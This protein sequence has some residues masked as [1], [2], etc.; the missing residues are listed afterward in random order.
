MRQSRCHGR[1]VLEGFDHGRD[2]TGLNHVG[3]QLT[4]VLMQAGACRSTRCGPRRRSAAAHAR[5]ANRAHLAEERIGA[6][7][8]AH[9]R[10]QFLG[11]LAEVGRRRRHHH[12]PEFPERLV[13]ERFLSSAFQ[14]FNS[15][16]RELKRCC[17]ELQR[18]ALDA[19][20][21]ACLRNGSSWVWK[22]SNR[23][24]RPVQTESE[25]APAE[26]NTHAARPRGESRRIIG[27]SA[28]DRKAGR[29][30]EHQASWLL[31]S[32]GTVKLGQEGAAIGAN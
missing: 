22:R 11:S 12:N 23:S 18:I 26:R 7:A 32:A 10:C 15:R 17:K 6:H 24:R 16:S 9:Q 13:T 3:Q 21:R 30:T 27:P 2:Q 29:R 4:T 14:R 19:V 1:G 25:E 8:L 20:R 31:R 28:A 5:A